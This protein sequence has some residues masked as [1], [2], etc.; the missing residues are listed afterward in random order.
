V[1][2]PV[3]SED[4][5]VFTCGWYGNF[6]YGAVALDGETGKTKWRFDTIGKATA[7]AL[8]YTGTLYVGSGE[9]SGVNA[10]QINTLYALKGATGELL[11][12]FKAPDWIDDI[13]V[14]ADDA[15]VFSAGRRLYCFTNGV[16]SW[17]NT[18]RSTGSLSLTLFADAQGSIATLVDY[19]GNVHSSIVS[20]DPATGA[21]NGVIFSAPSLSPGT[22]GPEGEMYVA[23]WANGGFPPELY[24]YRLEGSPATVK[25]RRSVEQTPDKVPPFSITADGMA[26]LGAMYHSTD[27]FFK[28]FYGG[29][30]KT[31][32]CWFFCRCA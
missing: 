4:G 21:T 20:V 12:K 23:A 11:W 29:S 27:K 19:S 3:V 8:G 26:Y 6:T 30:F 32:F 13:I 1:A 24:L 15:V 9:G 28:A 17:T 14:T 22:V 25:W 31:W 18:F 7:L 10:P 2:R 5:S 16:P